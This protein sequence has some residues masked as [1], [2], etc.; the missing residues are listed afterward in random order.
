MPPPHVGA[1]GQSRRNPDGRFRRR[2]GGASGLWNKGRASAGVDAPTDAV[3]GANPDGPYWF[4]P[5]QLAGSVDL[6][7]GI[8]S[9]AAEFTTRSESSRHP[10]SPRWPPTVSAGGQPGLSVTAAPAPVLEEAGNA[11][12]VTGSAGTH[13]ARLHELA[14][15]LHDGVGW[16]IDHVIQS[17]EDARRVRM[18][19]R[20]GRATRRRDRKRRVSIGLPGGPFTSPA[21]AVLALAPTSAAVQTATASNDFLRITYLHVSRRPVRRG[22]PT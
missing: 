4:S 19:F 1:R 8:A 20:V 2:P 7:V 22:F 16:P 5:A 11:G 6:F 14:G 13:K 9:G 10:V 17:G 12:S 15:R 18:V 3:R 21:K